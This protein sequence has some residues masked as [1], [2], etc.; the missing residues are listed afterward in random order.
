MR[1]TIVVMGT[2]DT[3]G[4]EL[5][6][7][8]KLIESRGHEALTID[9]STLGPPLYPTTIAR[10]EVFAARGFTVD[11]VSNQMEK[12]H[13]IQTATE[14]TI[15]IVERL[16]REG[17]VDGMIALGGG[18]GTVMGTSVMK[19][20]PFGLPKVMVSAV[21][22][23]LAP[24]GP[25]VGTKDMTIIHSV[26]DI[27]GLNAVTRRVLTEGVGAIV[28]MVETESKLE[29]ED[30]PAVGMTTAGVTTACALR[31]REVLETYGYEVIS[32]HCNGVG[33]QAMEELAE[34][35]RL[36][37]VLDLS[38]KDIPD[39]L[40][41]GIF[42]AHPERMKSTCARGIPQVIVPGTCDF[43]LF[44]PLSDVPEATLRRKHVVHNP[45]H[46]HV[47]ANREEM[48]A[49]GRFIGERLRE[50]RGPA[51]VLIPRGGFSQLNRAGGPMYEP[52]S[53]AGFRE[54]L[55]EDLALQEGG[56]VRVKEYDLHINDPEFARTAA[57]L[58]HSLITE[59][60]PR[61]G[62]KEVGGRPD[63]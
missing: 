57:E 4:E 13:A 54:G 31:I 34:S 7:V 37:G 36:A 42:P 20:L 16:L 10:Q 17:R 43:I 32:F 11:Q 6:F 1:K 59:N 46:T 29:G 22:N 3:K 24:F 18:Q 19:T 51:A 44:G 28:G 35:G 58:M 45:L 53:D 33:A 41:G 63:G 62:R 52:E 56:A 2:F 61:V 21:A 12:N 27:L 39:L 47:R 8:Q 50:S 48:A 49:V 55:T 9:C 5:R 38:P 14:G 23:G 40:F 15:R 26:A 60:D 30:R 25:F